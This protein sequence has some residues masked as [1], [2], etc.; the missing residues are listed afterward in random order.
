MDSIKIVKT[1]CPKLV[2]ASQDFGAMFFQ[3][4]AQLETTAFVQSVFTTFWAYFKLLP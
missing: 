3:R 4:D 2:Y 1:T